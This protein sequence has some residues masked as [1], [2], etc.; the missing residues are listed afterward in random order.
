MSNV[1]HKIFFLGNG[2]FAAAVI[3]ELAKQK[4]Q[5]D[6]VLSLAD[7]KAGRGQKNLELPVKSAINKTSYHF[8]EFSSKEEF[9]L[10]LETIKT[11][12]LIVADF[13]WIISAQNLQMVKKA[14]INIHPSLLSKYRGPSPM[15]SVILAG[16]K[17]TGVTLM[18]M[19]NQVDHGPI[20]AQEFIEIST[21]ETAESLILKTAAIGAKLLIKNLPKYLDGA[22]V[23]IDQNHQSA[24]FTQIIK[25]T[26]GLIDWKKPAVDIDRQVRALSLWPKAFTIFRDKHLIIHAGR[27]DDNQ[28]IPTQVQLEGR[29][30]I[31]WLD[32]LNGQRL[33]ESEALN[34]LTSKNKKGYADSWIRN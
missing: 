9:S 16:D 34:E 4:F 10:I 7:K 2:P 29:K 15:Q 21:D 26:D 13:G 20:I 23:P 1:K 22:L 11:D 6:G 8:L 24:T 25:K 12:I 33:K 28:F 5:L 17:S 3:E 31:S 32:F 14:A 27:I 18:K 30:I 19:D